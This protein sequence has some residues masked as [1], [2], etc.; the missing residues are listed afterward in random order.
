[1][2]LPFFSSIQS[3]LA[4]AFGSVSVTVAVVVFALLLLYWVIGNN[5]M[6]ALLMAL[7]PIVLIGFAGAIYDP[8]YMYGA[9][10]ILTF[11]LV[12]GLQKLFFK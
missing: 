9:I 8:A 12:Y 11:V 4:S 1:M 2:S 10:M 3:G 7:T 5:V 6:L